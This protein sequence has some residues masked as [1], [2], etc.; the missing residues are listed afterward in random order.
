MGG[1]KSM[2]KALI[3]LLAVL[4]AVSL[5]VSCGNDPFFHEVKIKYEDK[6]VRT[7]LVYDA[8]EYTLPKE[9]EGIP[10]I[11]GWTYGEK[12]YA[13]GE[14]IIVTSDITITAV[15][16]T[17]VVITL[18]DE[19]TKTVYVEKGQT[20][21]T[22]PEAPERAG[23]AFD[24]WDVDGTTYASGAKVK[25]TEGM[26]ITGLWKKIYTVTYLSNGGSGT[27]EADTFKEGEGVTIKDGTGLTHATLS[28]S[29]WNTQ[30]DGKG[31]AYSVGEK[32]NENKDLTLYA[33]WSSEITITY[34]V[35]GV[36][37]KVEKKDVSETVTLCNE[38]TWATAP[39]GF[40]FDGWYTQDKGEGKYFAGG[41]T[42]TES[43]ELYAH[44]IDED[45]EVDEDNNKAIKVNS[46]KTKTDI[47]SITIPS[48]YHGVAITSIRDDGFNGCTNLTSVS[49]EKASNITSIGYMAFLQCSA[50][51][52]IDLSETNVTEIYNSAFSQCKS[53]AEVILPT[54]LKTL[55]TGLF[56]TCPA[57]ESIS[58]PSTL[59]SISNM[60][61]CKSGLK[62]ITVPKSVESIGES[63]FEDCTALESVV[64]NGVKELKQ[65]TL[66]R[67]TALKSVTLPDTIESI[68]GSVFN[69]CS[70]LTIYMG[71]AKSDAPATLATDSTWGAT[72]STVV[73]SYKVGDTVQ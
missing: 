31:T 17:P 30:A 71:I 54:G 38:P 57:L 68:D 72:N 15:V 58:L 14:K 12:E 49:F 50:L 46:A 63:A 44:W 3:V 62:S 34:K 69:G 13:V 2:K 27:V 11:S 20:E 41:S 66:R 19:V 7:D 18:Y 33:V 21:L 29:G 9:V 36:D 56:H 40:V 16:G 51:K 5:F 47:T 64:I 59:T 48:V 32:Y 65:Y 8:S 10:E 55:T 42:V 1:V 23:Y 39:T 52:A 4:M 37:D 70:G 28:F 45:V 6:I 53:L 26:K 22:L 24:G 73:W 25:Y 67:C 61:F 35:S 43:L 60:A